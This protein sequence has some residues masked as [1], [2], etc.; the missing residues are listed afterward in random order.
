METISGV[1]ES[2]QPEQY[3]GQSSFFGGE[4][5]LSIGVGYMVVLGFGGAFSVFTTLIVYLEKRNSQQRITSED[6]K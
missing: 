4:A 6:F 5:P 1:V 3:G 2:N